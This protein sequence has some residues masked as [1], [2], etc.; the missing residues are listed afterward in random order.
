MTVRHIRPV[1][2]SLKQLAWHNVRK[3]IKGRET[4]VDRFFKQSS[5]YQLDRANSNIIFAP[6]FLILGSITTAGR[7]RSVFL[8]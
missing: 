4:G 3:A 2:L 6:H 5:C 8:G 7:T 1:E